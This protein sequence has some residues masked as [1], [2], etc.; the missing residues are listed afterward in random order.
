MKSNIYNIQFLSDEIAEHTIKKFEIV[1]KYVYD[2]AYKLLGNDQCNKLVYI[3]CMSNSGIYHT[4]KNE[5]IEGSPIRVIKSLKIV[6]ENFKEKK[7]EIFVYLNDNNFD[8]IE[9]LKENV[10]KIGLGSLIVS[11]TNKDASEMLAEFEDKI[12]GRGTHYFLLYD[13]YEA[14]LD[15]SALKPFLGNWGE[16][17]INHMVSDTIRAVKQVKNEN[18]KKK[19]EETYLVDKIEDLLTYGTDRNKYEE[20]INAIISSISEF[21]KRNTYIS[22]FPIFNAK[23]AVV[24]DLV[25]CTPSII[26]KRLF[27]KDVWQVFGDKSSNKRI[28]ENR[29]YKIG[30][31]I[32]AM[33]VPNTE[34]ECYRVSDIAGYLFSKFKGKTVNKKEIESE[35]DNHPVFPFDGYK[36]AIYDELKYLFNVK[37]KQKELIFK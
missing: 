10:N 22:S 26:G 33:I 6:S 1:S 11:I 18:K 15:W 8:K 13:P 28:S 5:I 31:D 27:K 30:G 36:K 24:Y 21:N 3:D 9:A 17:L 20:R 2:W 25:H 32:D 16:V 23:N 29:Q 35:L 37:V 14:I 4:K 12:S 19:Y 34:D 7:K